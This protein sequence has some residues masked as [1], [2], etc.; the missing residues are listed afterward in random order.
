[1]LAAGLLAALGLLVFLLAVGLSIA[2]PIGLILAGVATCRSALRGRI[3]RLKVAHGAR[4]L[5]EPTRARAA[6]LAHADTKHPALEAR[7][8]QQGT[9]G[10]L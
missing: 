1:L 3:E 6:Q 9:S 4:P 8:D 10:G 5:P 7:D 2:I